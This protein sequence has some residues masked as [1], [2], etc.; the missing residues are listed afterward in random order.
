MEQTNWHGIVLNIPCGHQD[1][2][3]PQAHHIHI[4]PVKQIHIKSSQTAK[5]RSQATINWRH[6]WFN[7]NPN[8]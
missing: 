7:A 6:F 1:L 2:F 8:F 3:S 4:V 5:Y